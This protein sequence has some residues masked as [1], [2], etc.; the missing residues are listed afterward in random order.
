MTEETF[1]PVTPALSG[2]SSPSAKP[3]G[4]RVRISDDALLDAARTCVLTAGLRRTT[5][6]E[7]ARTAGVSRMTLYRRFPDVG[8]ILSVLMT[9]EFGAVL[10]QADAEGAGAATAR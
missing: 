10:G 8:S 9:R 7:I 1:A 2:S 5:F 6:A 4:D 3:A